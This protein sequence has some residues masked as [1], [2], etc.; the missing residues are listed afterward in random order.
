VSILQFVAKKW[1]ADVYWFSRLVVKRPLR[2]Y[3]L[4]PARAIVDSVLNKRGLEFAI[5]F[6]RQSGKN[7]TQSQVEA[8][9][10]N[11]FQRVPGATIVKA[12][13]SFKPQGL[14]GISRLKRS[15][16]NDWNT[17]RTAWGA[18][19]PQW[20][21]VNDYQVILG[22]AMATFFSANP[23]AN[24]VGAT[25]SLLLECDEAQDVLEAE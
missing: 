6:P 12:Q 15:L 23:G 22:E 19:R 25:A 18:S 2:N 9:L 5:M 1:L 3:Q 17:T 4:A 21:T 7:E 14:N 16:Q 10:L 20:K 13:P 11:L 24:T 8:Y